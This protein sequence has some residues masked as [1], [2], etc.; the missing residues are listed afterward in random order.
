[1]GLFSRSNSGSKNTKNSKSD[2]KIIDSS[3][4]LEEIKEQSKRHKILIFKHSTRCGVSSMALN[5]LERQWQATSTEKPQRYFLDLLQYRN[6]SDEIAFIFSVSHQSPQ[7]LLI[8]N[9]KCVFH[10]SHSMIDLAD[11][12]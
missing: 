7:A 1:M 8:K 2:W 4:V 11:F 5:R 10:A 12:I 3:A 9:G 6:L